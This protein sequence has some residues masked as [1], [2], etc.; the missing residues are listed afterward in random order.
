MHKVAETR[1]IYWGD[2]RPSRAT[3]AFIIQDFLGDAAQVKW[4]KADKIFRIKMHG[5]PAFPYR[6]TDH[7]KLDIEWRNA[8]QEEPNGHER[9]IT[10][11]HEAQSHCVVST[12]LADEFTHTL[13]DGLADL[14]LGYFG[15]RR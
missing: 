6:R 4:N 5:E 1:T 10:V 13:A 3:M 7:P 15:A 2:T 12:D 14:L 8:I 11:D 9:L